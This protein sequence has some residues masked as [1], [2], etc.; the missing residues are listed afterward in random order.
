MSSYWEGQS[1]AI[2]GEHSPE[3]FEVAAYRLVAE[4]VLYHADRNSRTAYWLLDRFERDFRHALAPLGIDV[5]VNRQLRYACAL[6]RHAKTGSA[7]VVQTLLALVLRGIY[8]E[9][10]R[11]G[12]LNEHGEIS[13]D[14][15]ELAE[16][17][18][19]AAGRDLPGKGEFDSLMRTMQRWGIARKG[20]ETGPEDDECADQPYTVVIRPAIADV[21]GET[22]LSRLAQWWPGS[23]SAPAPSDKSGGEVLEND[24]KEQHAEQSN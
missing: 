20:E 23:E 2:E 1:A 7:S 24:G 3:E 6:P 21:L 5:L 18:R 8:D 22:A 15:V 16:K 17:Y 10:A 4:Q 9:G 11:L 14:L 13:C 12:Q 19:L